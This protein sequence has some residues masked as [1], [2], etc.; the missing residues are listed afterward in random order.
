M[1][2]DPILEALEAGDRVDA[3]RLV[4][5]V[6]VWV[7]FRDPE[8]FDT[9]ECLPVFSSPE[10]I[11]AYLATRGISEIVDRPIKAQLIGPELFQFSPHHRSQ[12]VL[13]PSST[14]E[15]RLTEEEFD[16]IESGS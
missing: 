16:Y 12:T 2:E 8:Y 14:S 5:D 1:N 13:N 3:I 9:D 10:Q 7:P 15:L 4:R 6:G 11:P